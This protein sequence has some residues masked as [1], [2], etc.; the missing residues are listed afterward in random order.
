MSAT[1]LNQTEAALVQVSAALATGRESVVREALVGALSIDPVQV[2]EAILQAY[3][4]LGYP[5]ALNGLALW[6]E[7][8]GRAPAAPPS[9]DGPDD[10][11]ERGARICQIVYGGQYPRLR[12]NIRA[13]HPDMERWMIMEGYGK[14]L[15]R[16]GLALELR[17]L[18]VVAVLTVLGA[19]RQLYSHL[20]GALNAGASPARVEAALDVAASL[21]GP[22]SKTPAR[23]V[24]H[25]VQAR[26]AASGSQG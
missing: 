11:A 18:C 1:I 16:P 19:S 22:D 23:Q 26:A 7:V 24:W 17:E 13:L 25:A 14:V 12:D 4:F 9:S 5:A 3:L 21:A 10:W 8:S 2:E 15:G 6:R 20:R